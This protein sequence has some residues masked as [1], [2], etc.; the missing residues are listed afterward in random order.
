MNNILLKFRRIGVVLLAVMLLPLIASASTLKQIG[1]L[2]YLLNDDGTA[3]VVNILDI[4][5]KLENVVIPERVEA[6]INWYGGEESY[7]VTGIEN[8]AFYDC[9]ALK[10]VVLPCT[11]TTIGYSVFCGCSNLTAV[12]LPAY[13]QTIGQNAFDGCKSLKE[14]NFPSSLKSIEANAFRDCSGLTNVIFPVSLTCIEQTAFWDCSGLTNIE[15][16]SGLESIGGAAFGGCTSIVS[17]VCAAEVPPTI[18]VMAFVENSVL[19]GATLYVP[20]SS[21]DAYRNSEYEWSSFRSIK[22][23]ALAD[24]DAPEAYDDGITSGITVY[25][26]DGVCVSGDVRNLKPGV[27]VV[28]QKNKIRKLLVK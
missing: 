16:P 7:E 22:S 26:L 10:N 18:D 20:E 17:I 19:S 23:L 24:I 28:K 4:N 12:T 21:I 25:T 5:K 8:Y 9:T 13:L 27:Y 15:L 14:I 6:Q 11:I 1:D 3:T 2:V